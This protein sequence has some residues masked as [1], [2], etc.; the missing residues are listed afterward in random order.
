MK[1]VNRTT[2][3]D[4]VE[5]LYFRKAGLPS[6]P[7]KAA[8]GSEALKVE[9]E[10]LSS[11]EPVKQAPST[12]RAALRSYELDSADFDVLEASTKYLYRKTMQELDEDLGDLHVT[13]F[14][15]AFLLQLRNG[16]A[17]RG[18]RAAA[19][20]MQVLKNALW[21]A[22]VAGQMGQVTPSR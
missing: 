1:Y 6:V 18:Y 11:L 12:L 21:P 5:R 22:I 17:P 4:G 20:R 16:W 9:V 13:S 14:T 15:S 3:R 19:I 2:G 8:W 10:A 7:L